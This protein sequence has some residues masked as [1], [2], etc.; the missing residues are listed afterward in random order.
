MDRE[1]R[2]GEKKKDRSGREWACGGGKV[3]VGGD[4]DPDTKVHRKRK[5]SNTE[6]VMEVYK[7]TVVESGS[8]AR[9]GG[10]LVM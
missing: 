1:F 2:K 10:A 4:S 6:K 5:V 9:G 7:L 8:G 3:G